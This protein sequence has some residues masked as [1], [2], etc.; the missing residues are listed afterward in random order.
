[1]QIIGRYTGKPYTLREVEAFGEQC[2]TY[3][4]ERGYGP[5]LGYASSRHAT[6]EAVA[7]RVQLDDFVAAA[8]GDRSP[9][10]QVAYEA[11][12]LRLGLRIV[13]ADSYGVRYG[14]FSVTEHGAEHTA[15]MAL[16][17]RRMK[18]IDQEKIEA[19]AEALA[20]DEAKVLAAV[21]QE[22][23]DATLQRTIPGMPSVGKTCMQRGWLYRITEVRTFVAD[24][25]SP[26][27]YGG[28]FLGE[29]GEVGSHVTMA[30][31][32]RDE[33]LAALEQH[34]ERCRLNLA[35]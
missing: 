12:A 9:L 6:S 22:A 32:S 8:Q 13:D 14:D 34:F 26:S 1:M 29:E 25:D 17:Y 19:A 28:H 23:T 7:A 35:T 20:V 5:S 30:A 27:V 24:A 33:T 21:P 4:D 31:C 10:S 15:T 16:A 3:S 2:W 11:E 18:A